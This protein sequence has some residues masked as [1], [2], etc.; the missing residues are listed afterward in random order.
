MSALYAKLPGRSYSARAS[1]A[2]RRAVP[3]LLISQERARWRIASQL[4]VPGYILFIYQQHRAQLLR[5]V[6][7]G[8]ASHFIYAV[9]HT[10]SAGLSLRMYW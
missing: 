3:R 5:P 8:A 2:P 1:P 9:M 4:Y 7:R 6:G 10:L